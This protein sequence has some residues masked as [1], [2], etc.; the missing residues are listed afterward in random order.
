MLACFLKPRP[1][2]VATV[3]LLSAVPIASARDHS[4]AK[5]KFA[6]VL[7]KD[8]GNIRA[9]NLFWGIGGEKNQP[10]LPVEFIS[11]EKHGSSPKFDVHDAEGK[12]W[13]AKIGLE[14]KPETAASR[15]LWAIGY[16]ANENYFFNDL[17]VANMPATIRKGRGFLGRGGD[18]PNVRLQRHAP[19]E[20]K[21]GNWS[22]QHNPFYGTREFNGL[23]VMMGLIANWDLKDDN[24]A[25]FEQEKPGK[26]D[27]KKNSAAGKSG[28]PELEL[29]EVSDVGTAF[30][31]PGKRYSDRQSKGNLGAFRR[32]AL[33]A[34]VHKDYID[35][36]FPKRPPLQSLFE[37]DWAFFFH[38]VGIGWIGKHIPRSDAKWVGSLLAQLS[39]DQIR[40]AFRAAGYSPEETQAYTDAVLA[41][42]KELNA[43]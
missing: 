1:Y 33:I 12:K 37:F 22:W 31:T 18:V 14:A 41:R 24:N 3:L 6:A 21:I 19:G 5:E 13:T 8:P 30:G 32:T 35:L 2:L 9:R 20:K 25:I 40:D 34:H 10:Q 39:P 28:P 29:Y 43:L 36:N 23:R 7:W 15:L 4:K 16:G 38:Q 27:R 42:I 11:D 17:Q 26:D